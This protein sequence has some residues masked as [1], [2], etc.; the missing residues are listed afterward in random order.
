MGCTTNEILLCYVRGVATLMIDTTVHASPFS[1]SI[2]A[3]LIALLA[4]FLLT[5]ERYPTRF[6]GFGSLMKI[7]T[8]AIEILFHR[9]LIMESLFIYNI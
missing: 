3:S 8:F 2:I 4:F 9:L 1:M 7:E 5:L 6:W